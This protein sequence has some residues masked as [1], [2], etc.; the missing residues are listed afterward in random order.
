MPSR[1]PAAVSRLCRRLRPRRVRVRLT[2][3]YG[4]LFLASGAVL[5]A[6][7]YLLVTRSTGTT[8][9]VNQSGSTV[10]VEQGGPSD[11]PEPAADVAV[12]EEFAALREEAARQHERVLDSLLVQSGVA[13]AIMA[14]IAMALGWVVAGRVLRPL[15]TMTTTIRQISARNVNERLAV[16][17]PPDELKDLADTVDGLLGRLETALESHKRF[18]ANAAHELRTPLTLEHALLEESLTDPGATVQT[19]RRTVRRLL[20][21]RRQQA[22]LLESLLTLSTSERGLDRADPLDLSAIAGRVLDVFR[23]A[24]DRR[25][26]RVDADLAPPGAAVAPGDPALVERLVAN[27]LDNAVD[28]NV[29]GGRVA[30]TPRVT[31]DGRAEVSVANTGPDLPP[32]RVDGLFEPFQ[33]LTRTADADHH[34]LGLSI[35]RAIATAHGADLTARARPGGGLRVTATFPPRSPAEAQSRSPSRSKA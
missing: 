26:L 6:I 32:E 12:R 34:G 15:R 33:R 25:G 30:V 18:V 11:M 31:G 3:L 10:R 19:F 16:A 29:P 28:Y 22:R 4:V 5:L 27:L 17:G 7:T 20:L 9:Y 35:V 23:P 2:L 13:L 8:V 1:L 24:L 14:V 21:G